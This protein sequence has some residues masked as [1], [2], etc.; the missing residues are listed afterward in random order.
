MSSYKIDHVLEF[1]LGISLRLKSISEEVYLLGGA[2]GVL[3]QQPFS[4][5]Q[6]HVSD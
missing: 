4:S 3:A 1:V 2:D 6:V 5:L